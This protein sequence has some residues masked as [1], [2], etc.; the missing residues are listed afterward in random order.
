MEKEQG[1]QIFDQAIRDNKDAQYV[2]QSNEQSDILTV[3]VGNLEP[4]TSLTLEIH[5]F[6]LLTQWTEGKQLL[7]K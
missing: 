2:S 5:L 4:Q 7:T 1:K 6:G 3:D